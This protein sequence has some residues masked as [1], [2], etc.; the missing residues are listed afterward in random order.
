LTGARERFTFEHMVERM[1]VNVQLATLSASCYNAGTIAMVQLGYRLWGLLDRQTFVATHDAWWF[2]PRG[3]KPVIFPTAALALFGSAAMLRY[4]ARNASRPLLRLNMALQLATYVATA[5]TWGRWQGQLSE[6]RRPDG[7]L[8][9]LYR[10]LLATHWLRV[11]LIVGSAAVQL[12]VAA[13]A[14]R[15][16]R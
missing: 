16:D 7:S 5:A 10:K 6:T 15:D 2:G 3:I 11:A 4:P 9:P 13:S 12:R 14:F 8:D 1:R